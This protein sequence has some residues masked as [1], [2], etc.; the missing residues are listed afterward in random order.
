MRLI[1]TAAGI[2]FLGIGIAGIVLPMLPG[3]VF[4]L[5][6]S[7]CFVRGSDRLHG[8][9]VTHP[10]LGKQL[11]ILRGEEPMPARAKVVAISAM[12]IAV[13]LSIIGTEI[14]A[15]QVVLAVLAVIGTFFIMRRR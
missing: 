4:L 13:T 1:W 9:L 8:W 11:R 6:A 7:A 2:V 14:V 15:V 12:W 10:V 3:T 5:A